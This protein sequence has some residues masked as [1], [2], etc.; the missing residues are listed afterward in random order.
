MNGWNFQNSYSS[1]PAHFYQRALP[2]PV[3][4]PRM[5]FFNASL[6]D[7]LGFSPE[8]SSPAILA[9]HFAGN[10]IFNGSEPI[11]QAYAGHQFAHFTMLGDGRAILLGEHLTPSGERFDV[12]L[13]GSGPTPYSRRGDGRAALGPMIRE[14]IIS[15][16]MHALGIPTTRSLAVVSTG[17]PVYR[18]HSLQGAILTRIARSHIRVGTFQFAAAT[19]RDDGLKKLADYTIDRHYPECI[20]A[21]TRYRDFLNAVIDRQAKLVSQWMMVGFIHGVM[22]TDNMS[23]CG[24]TIDYGP[25]AFMDQYHPDTVFSS[26]DHHGRYAYGNQP[27]IAQWNLARFSE[28][29]LPL[30]SEDR[31][32]ALTIAKEAI[33]RFPASFLGYWLQGMRSKL[34]LETENPG[35]LDL[36][37]R[38]L[39]LMLKHE[40][41]YTYTFRTLSNGGSTDSPLFTDAEFI[42]WKQDWNQR[43]AEEGSTLESAQV[44][45]LSLNPAVIPRNHLVEEALLA[46]N[47]S[48]NLSALEKLL[49]ALKNPYAET[50]VNVR[51]REPPTRTDPDYRTFCGT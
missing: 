6:A 29:L 42:K 40:A 27:V 26:I 23:I 17:E 46:A 33:D 39:S 7:A 16:G 12:Q 31:G 49:E 32:A 9:S 19:Q 11:A 25:C 22:N 50:E 45:M 34:G 48:G 47:E 8:P 20:S 5:V 43:L 4:D 1:L 36:S 41:D 35:D 38:L 30:L 18:D 2:T 15:E 21:T 10:S 13:K 14:L 24:E 37:N 28:T 51:Y 44:R 3:R